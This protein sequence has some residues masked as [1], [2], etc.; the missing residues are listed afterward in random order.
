MNFGDNS[1]FGF[2]ALLIVVLLGMA[3]ASTFSPEARE[4]RRRRRNY[5]RVVSRARRPMVRLNTKT[6]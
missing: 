2:V 4:R 3:L 6:R 5:G 1:A